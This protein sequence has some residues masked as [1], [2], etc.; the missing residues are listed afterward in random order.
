MEQAKEKKLQTR[1]LTA[2]LF[3]IMKNVKTFERTKIE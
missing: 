2:T 3:I 1:G